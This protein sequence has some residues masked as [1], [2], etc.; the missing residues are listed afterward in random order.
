MTFCFFCLNN[1]RGEKGQ[2]KTELDVKIVLK[3]NSNPKSQNE[4]FS[5]L[6]NRHLDNL[7]YS[8]YRHQNSFSSSWNIKS[9]NFFS[10][11]HLG[12]KIVLHILWRIKRDDH[13]PPNP[14]SINEGIIY[15]KLT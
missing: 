12:K 8:G 10:I 2:F 1:S 9:E 5:A 15:G 4:N 13:R 11:R 3:K 14:K 7:C 6:F